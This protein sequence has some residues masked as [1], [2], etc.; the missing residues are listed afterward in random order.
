MKNRSIKN[1]FSIFLSLVP[2][3][4][5]GCATSPEKSKQLIP[6]PSLMEQEDRL[7][8]SALA[9]QDHRKDPFSV[10]ADR[11]R[12]RAGE[13]EE[14]GDLPNAL[15][16]W[17]IVK[18]FL[19]DDEEA[20]KRITRLKEEIPAAADLH[21]RNGVEFFLNHS[22]SLAQKE[23]LLALYLNPDHGEAAHYLREKMAGD[24]IL[25]Y[26]VRRG[27]TIKKVARKFYKDPQKDFLIAYFNGLKVDDPLEPPLILR[28]PIVD[29]SPSKG[30]STSTKKPAEP[31]PETAKNIQEILAKAKDAYRVKNYQE[32]AALSAKG[33]EVDP[34]N[35]ECRKLK[36]ASFYALGKKLG[37]EE[38]PSEALEA[39]RRVDSGYKDTR[40]Q[41]T[42]NQ[43]RLA[44]VHYI[45]GVKLYIE[46]KIEGAIQEWETTLALEP[47]H[48]KAKNDIENAR[49]LLRKLEKV[50]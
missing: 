9:G 38:K 48:P 10:L 43:K 39:F 36:N 6:A 2:I 50:R 13:N 44:E 34:A 35:S 49:N 47:R 25:T 29:P 27:D 1:L 23:F 46:E 42:R 7:S 22:Y 33:L 40:T 31:N 11:Y 37:Q 30:K 32:S 3:F 4:L 18:S 15:K 8:P 12:L 16:A 14:A 28:M 41:V 24:D 45:N 17:E 5:A 20:D 26:E 19:P 21:F